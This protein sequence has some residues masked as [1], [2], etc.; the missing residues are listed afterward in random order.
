MP[1]EIYD[2]FLTHEWGTQISGFATH[3]EVLSVSKMLIK[4]GFSVWVD[5][6]NL[7]HY[8][9]KGIVEGLEA[10][11]K[12]IVFVTERY[13]K[14]F[15]D[16]NTNCAKELNSAMKKGQENVEVVVLEDKFLDPRSWKGTVF[17][18]HLG[19]KSTSTFHLNRRKKVILKSFMN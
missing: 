15:G 4:R 19:H 2:C 11:K 12:V 3:E 17:E 13:L 7:K 14:R 8:I 5:E 1:A 10:S 6:R 18:Y 9:A 16:M